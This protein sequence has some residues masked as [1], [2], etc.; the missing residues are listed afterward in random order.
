MADGRR[1]VIIKSLEKSFKGEGFIDFRN[2]YSSEEVAKY[3]MMEHCEEDLPELEDRNLRNTIFEF[4]A[5][6]KAF[7]KLLNNKKA[8]LRHPLASTD[9]AYQYITLN[10]DMTN[11]AHAKALK[12]MLML[13]PN[14]NETGFGAKREKAVLRFYQILGFDINEDKFKTNKT[15]L[16]QALP[17]KIYNVRSYDDFELIPDIFDEMEAVYNNARREYAEKVNNLASAKIPGVII[18]KGNI[19]TPKKFLPASEALSRSTLDEYV[20]GNNKVGLSSLLRTYLPVIHGSVIKDSELKAIIAN[21]DKDASSLIS[22]FEK[23]VDFYSNYTR[24]QDITVNDTPTNFISLI[25]AISR[26][27]EQAKFGG[28][29]NL[30]S[31]DALAFI[32]KSNLDLTEDDDLLGAL[33]KSG[34]FLQ[35]FKFLPKGKK[36]DSPAGISATITGD[37]KGRQ[38]ARATERQGTRRI[39]LKISGVSSFQAGINKSLKVAFNVLAME[40]TGLPPG[41]KIEID[42]PVG[43]YTYS[44]TQEFAEEFDD[45]FDPTQ[46]FTPEEISVLKK[47]IGT[48][49]EIEKPKEKEREVSGIAK[50]PEDKKQKD[51]SKSSSDTRNKTKKNLP[52]EV[53]LPGGQKKIKFDKN[54]VQYGISE[55]LNSSDEQIIHI[56][57]LDKESYFNKKF[58]VFA[59]RDKDGAPDAPLINPD[60]NV[61]IISLSHSANTIAIEMKGAGGFIDK[62]GENAITIDTGTDQFTGLIDKA[63]NSKKGSITYIDD[64]EPGSKKVLKLVCVGSYEM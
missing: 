11:S 41:T 5:V 22:E 43:A 60:V 56:E 30:A 20:G 13:L 53:V 52:N 9:P 59:K 15:K 21:L 40:L 63:K 47:L 7:F 4:N 64:S 25:A 44:E 50:Y 10:F 49:K 45:S 32:R 33:I 37:V 51:T 34:V 61:D 39:D 14:P 31:D 29:Y 3:F 19:F 16:I 12:N 35:I 48:A 27:G 26:Y 17:Y 6:S 57:K 8:K 42:L 18:E 54:N 62:T 24:T 58:K 38:R 36:L 28:I 46:D 23:N 55:E 1:Y 2:K